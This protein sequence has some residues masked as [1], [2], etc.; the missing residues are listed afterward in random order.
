VYVAP[1]SLAR[2]RNP[3]HIATFHGVAKFGRYQS[4]ADIGRAASINLDL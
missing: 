2:I 4:L 3:Q 1:M